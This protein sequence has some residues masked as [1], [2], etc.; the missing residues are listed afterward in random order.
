MTSLIARYLDPTSALEEV[1]F[2]LIMVLSFT[3][4]ASLIVS[5][6]P[7]A[8]RAMLIGIVGCNVA[9]G[10][11]D[12]VMYLL[13]CM[14]ER[15]RKSRLVAALQHS[16]NDDVAVSAIARQLDGYLV[17]L[18]SATERQGIYHSILGRLRG[19]RPERVRLTRDDLAAAAVTCLLVVMTTIPAVLP[20]F[21][22]SDSFLALRISN[23]LL[24]VAIF[25]AGFRWAQATHV[26]PWLTGSGLLLLGIGLVSVAVVFGG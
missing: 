22:T 26:N 11:I 1:L 19:L 16:E 4:G 6:G 8:T 18:T 23:A 13:D 5:E 12:G 3:V 2:G 17:P 24:L 25:A 20:F 9:W 21:F 7:A 14:L 15:S 10:V